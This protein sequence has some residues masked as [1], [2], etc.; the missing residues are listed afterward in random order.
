[1]R[2]DPIGVP[3]S[4]AAAA[5]L[6]WWRE[7]AARGELE[8][9]YLLHGRPGDPPVVCLATDAGALAVGAVCGLDALWAALAP[10]DLDTS[11][12][13]R[14]AIAPLYA[15]RRWGPGWSGR[16]LLCLVDSQAVCGALNRGH[17]RGD[18]TSVV[19]AIH[20]LALA[21]GVRLLAAWC[22]R[23]ANRWADAL[24]KAESADEAARVAGDLGLRLW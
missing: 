13:R 14:E 12:S 16:V 6:A 21:L 15:L 24:S 23:E 5:A 2:F 22:P 18:G 19:E 9:G 7:T 4:A 11:S 8:P 17:L 1:V 3:L 10:E 20:E